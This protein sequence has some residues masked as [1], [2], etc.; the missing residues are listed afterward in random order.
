MPVK[1]RVILRSAISSASSGRMDGT[2]RGVDV[3]HRTPA[4][5]G[6]GSWLPV[7][8]MIDNRPRA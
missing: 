2:D 6:H 1:A 5:W 4:S 7:P 8:M 3:D